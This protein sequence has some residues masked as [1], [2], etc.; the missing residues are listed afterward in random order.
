MFSTASLDI[1]NS[2]SIARQLLELSQDPQSQPYICAENGCVL[3]LVSYLSLNDVEVVMMSARTLQ[4]LSSHPQNKKILRDFPGLVDALMGIYAR[5]NVNA[6][7]REFTIGTLENLGVALNDQN[8]DDADKENTTTTNRFNKA[9]STTP[10]P[11]AKYSTLTIQINSLD[12]P[13]IASLSQRILL[14]TAGVI[15]VTIDKF[16]GL[17]VIGTRTDDKSLLEKIQDSLS[18]AGLTSSPWPPPATKNE[19]LNSSATSDDSGY[20]NESDFETPQ[21]GASG[22]ISK[23][24]MSSLEARLEQQRREEEARKAKTDDLLSKVGSI[25]ASASSWLLG[26]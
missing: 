20:L 13:S 21:G 16:R 22:A 23:Y 18:N 25:V 15:S 10:T 17:A 14:N 4:F 3:G 8:D 2:K 11:A 19:S 5:K 9:S 1:P 26:W 7:T 24:G 12:D 6:K